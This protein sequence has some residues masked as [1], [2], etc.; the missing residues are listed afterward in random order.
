MPINPLLQPG[1]PDCPGTQWGQQGVVFSCPVSTVAG[2]QLRLG[3]P[4]LCWGWGGSPALPGGMTSKDT[5][6]KEKVVQK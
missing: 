6:P 4:A 5:D 1:S 2:S 3:A